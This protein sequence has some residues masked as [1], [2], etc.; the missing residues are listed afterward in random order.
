MA[1]KEI[2]VVCP[3]EGADKGKRFAITRMSAIEADKW[4][5]HCLQAAAASGADIPGVAAGGGLAAVAAAGIGI[6]AAIRPE[7]MDE[8]LD[9]L[10]QTVEL[11]PDPSNP[12]TRLPWAVAQTQIEEIPTIGWLQTEAFKLHVDFFKGVGRLFSLLSLMLG[13]E[14]QDPSPNPET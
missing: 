9:R 5:R 4:G 12:A 7:R 13:T 11:L 14:D 10:M 6:F 1:L 8:L 3:H 2:T